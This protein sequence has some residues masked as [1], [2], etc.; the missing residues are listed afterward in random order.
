MQSKRESIFESITSV[1]IGFFVALAS[2]L[3]LFPIF[4]IHIAFSSNLLM[5]LYFTIISII[6]GYFVRRWFNARIRRIHEEH[7]S[8][9]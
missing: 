7:Q 9:N 3:V 2:Q 8:R 1:V 6:R 5:S 4:D